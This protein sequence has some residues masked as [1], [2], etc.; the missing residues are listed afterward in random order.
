MDIIAL[1]KSAEQNSGAVGSVAAGILV[2][3][4]WLSRQVYSGLSKR[5]SMAHEHARAAAEAAAQAEDH[6]REDIS[7]VYAD[8][9]GHIQRDVDMHH[10]VLGA[11]K[12]QTSTLHGI[13]TS[14][15]TELADRPTRDE[16]EKR[17]EAVRQAAKRK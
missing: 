12:E 16:V 8:L 2:V 3:I 7:G 15:L 14:L 5:I 4:G 17:V 1:L 11:L 9:N 10:E 6:R 13:H